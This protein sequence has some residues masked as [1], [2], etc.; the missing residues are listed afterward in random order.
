MRCSYSIEAL[1]AAVR[2][3][4]SLRGTLRKLGLKVAG[5]SSALLKAKIESL[6]LDTSH[7]FHPRTGRP[8]I[9]ASYVCKCCG[10]V[11]Q[12]E[13][14][15]RKNT[16]C[17]EV[18]LAVGRSES[19]ARSGA[20]E[21]FREGNRL[22]Q[23][24]SWAEPETRERRL[25][26]MSSPSAHAKRIKAIRKAA[27]SP[28]LRA[29]RSV[30]ARRRWEEDDELRNKFQ[31]ASKISRQ[32]RS[33]NETSPRPPHVP[34][35]GLGGPIM[36]RSKWERDFACWL[37][38]QCLKWQY[39]PVR[40]VVEGRPYTP[41]FYVLSPFGACYVELHRL[42][43][44]PRSDLKPEKMRK[45]APLLEAPLILIS[46]DGIKAIRQQLRIAT[47]QPKVLP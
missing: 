2:E 31:A 3:S 15:Q 4:T 1:I 10:R 22:T 5:G 28:E 9:D 36:V 38:R 34:Y 29:T 37:D 25:A 42:T 39:E 6:G 30:N 41:D 45:A 7:F 40:V 44:A 21:S 8:R 17:S 26:A 43:T 24:K 18:C 12:L 23:L 14:G 13:R 46:E 19:L 16:Y 11:V 47:R 27:L 20:R 33:F 35:E 32:E